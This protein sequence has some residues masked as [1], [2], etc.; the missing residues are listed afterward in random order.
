MEVRANDVSIIFLAC[1]PSHQISTKINF[2]Q[3]EDFSAEKTRAEQ[4][5]LATFLIDTIHN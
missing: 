1:L 5:S 3:V 4:F 2:T